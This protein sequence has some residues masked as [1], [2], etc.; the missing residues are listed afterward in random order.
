MQRKLK[1]GERLLL[2]AIVVTLGALLYVAVFSGAGPVPPVPTPTPTS[3]FLA[4]HPNPRPQ[5]LPSKKIG[6]IPG[7]WQNDSGATCEDGLTEAEITLSVARKVKDLLEWYGYE[8]ELLPE[9]SPRILGYV[10]DAFLAIHADSC[11]PIEGATGFKVARVQNSA[12]PAV[13]DRLA[14]CLWEEYQAATGLPRHEGSIT[15][16]ML[17]YHALKEIAPETP[18][19]II[20]IG[21]LRLDREILVLRQDAVAQ[22]LA[23]ALICFLEGGP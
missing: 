18:G 23:N 5:G 9:F 10:A 12:I 20:E 17:H 15:N 19:A 6:I 13:D 16:D 21:F 22:G 11:E 3:I 14:A 2:G 1:W 4:Q 8:V 7:H